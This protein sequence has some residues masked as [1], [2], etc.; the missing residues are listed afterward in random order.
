[1]EINQTVQQKIDHLKTNPAC[2]SEVWEV[3]Q[4]LLAMIQTQAEAL[5]R[6]TEEVKRFQEQRQLDSHNSSKPPSSDAGHGQRTPPTGRQP[7][8]KRPGGQPGHDGTTLRQVTQPDQVVVH[9]VTV[10]A[11]CGHDVSHLP[12]TAISKRQVFDVPPLRLEVTEHQ[13]EQ[14][15]CAVC[16]QITSAA[17]PPGLTHPTQYGEGVKSILVYL[18]QYQLLPH[19]RTCELVA[20]LLGQPVSQGT[21]LNGTQACYD[22]LES[23][24]QAVKHALQTAP[25]VQFD[26]TGL[27]EQGQRIWLHSAS[28]NELTYYAAHP[29]RGTVGMAAAGI[30]PG[31][32]GVAVPDHWESYQRYA[33]CDHAFC[34]AHHLRELTR[35]YEQEQAQWAH[36]LKELL[37]SCHAQVDEA[38][39]QGHVQL[40]P[41]IRESRHQEYRAILTTALAIYPPDACS[42]PPPRGRRKQSKAKN[43]LDR[44]VTYEQ[45]TLRF[46][47]DFAVPFD[48]NLAERD[49]RM[50]KVK[51]KISGC[52]RST[53]G[54]KQFCRIRGFI[55]T[56]K[57]QQHNVLEAL[58]AVFQLPSGN[59][60]VNFLHI[61]V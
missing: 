17:F 43:L 32:S 42:D 37:L 40:A 44:L 13:A 54:T 46:M 25:V 31:F 45:E 56:L 55:S 22:H 16:H 49:I 36:D 28:T 41:A 52:F 14:K 19:A 48:N 35:A 5:T 59:T 27:Y 39:Q 11:H 29:K 21:L 12:P 9:P 7:S 60:S 47:D 34:N 51:Q 23:T 18:N 8:G 61:A 53:E 3:I 15:R 26:E 24:E 2:P 50:T 57:K 30:L 38:K 4:A 1:M 6:L 58:K 20:D 33:T 10:C